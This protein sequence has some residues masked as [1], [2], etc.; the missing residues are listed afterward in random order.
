MLQYSNYAF[1]LSN[2]AINFS[3]HHRFSSAHPS[4]SFNC[5]SQ[6]VHVIFLLSKLLFTLLQYT[7]QKQTVPGI[8]ADVI[9]TLKHQALCINKRYTEIR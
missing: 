5:N 8:S 3:S 7:Q 4:F 9:I 6:Y 2:L 1:P